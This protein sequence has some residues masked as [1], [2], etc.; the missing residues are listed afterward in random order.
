MARHLML[1]MSNALPGREVEFNKW[2]DEIHLRDVLSHPK[3]VTAERFLT[4]GAP[5][6]KHEYAA[7]FEMECDDP[8]VAYRELVQMFDKKKLAIGDAMASDISVIFLTPC[9]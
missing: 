6:P 4:S 3:F 5:M 9:R 1:V 8:Q 7:I 2:Y